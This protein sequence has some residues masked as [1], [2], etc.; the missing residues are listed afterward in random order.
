MA[1][2]SGQDNVTGLVK[3]KILFIKYLGFSPDDKGKPANT[4]EAVCTSSLFSTQ[5]VSSL[6]PPARIYGRKMLIS[7]RFIV[8]WAISI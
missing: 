7:H 6:G 5:M 8:L 2:V 4:D 3:K 1:T